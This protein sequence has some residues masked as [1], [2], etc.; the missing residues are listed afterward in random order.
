M[1]CSMRF[2]IYKGR[3]EN[4]SST[5]QLGIVMVNDDRGQVVQA[6]SGLVY[7]HC[8]ADRGFGFADLQFTHGYAHSSPSGLSTDAQT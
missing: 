7:L 4:E 6:H 3:W 1:R 2:L 8:C 5:G